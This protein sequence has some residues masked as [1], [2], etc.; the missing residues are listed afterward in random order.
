M[1]KPQ[2]CSASVSSIKTT[3]SSTE[4]TSISEGSFKSIN[5][6]LRSIYRSWSWLRGQEHLFTKPED[7][8]LNPSTHEKSW[9]W[10]C[11]PGGTAFQGE[12][13]WI[14]RAYWSAENDICFTGDCVSKH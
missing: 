7:L 13:K 14:L 2:M 9:V 5:S 4:I 12:D 11:V 3:E 6:F 1:G 10:L 8:S